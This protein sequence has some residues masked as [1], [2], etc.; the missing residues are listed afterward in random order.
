MKDD[1]K[2][3]MKLGDIMDMERAETVQETCGR[4]R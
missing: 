1:V 4:M 3:D 2:D